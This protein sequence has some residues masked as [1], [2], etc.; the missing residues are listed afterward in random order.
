MKESV[1]SDCGTYI[2]VL[3]CSK[4]MKLPIGKSGTLAANRGYYV[5]IGSAFGPGGIKSRLR[6][7]GK[8]SSTPHWHIDYLRIET[9]IYKAY[10]FYS[11]KHRE[12][13]WA[14]VIAENSDSIEPLKGF[15]SSDCKCRT[16]LY[17]FRTSKML[18]AAISEISEAK[19]VLIEEEQPAM[20]GV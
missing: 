9:V 6:H 8:I 20:G 15:G 5:Y 16:H 10:A 11:Y 7:H 12:C 4:A 19:E 1:K 14:A 2:V 13:D 17:F 3:K 18:D